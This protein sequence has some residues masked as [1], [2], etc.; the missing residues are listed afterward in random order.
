MQQPQQQQQ[1]GDEGT[2]GA[3]TQS[4]Q[5]GSMQQSSHNHQHL[6]QDQHMTEALELPD[7][8]SSTPNSTHFSSSLTSPSQG[9]L[10]VAE[11]S[12]A[13]QAREA[14]LDSSIHPASSAGTT[15]PNDAAI[16]AQASH[17]RSDAAGEAMY[18]DPASHSGMDAQPS[19]GMHAEAGPT[20]EAD[21]ADADADD[22]VADGMPDALESLAVASTEGHAPQMAVLA[23]LDQVCSLCTACSLAPTHAQHAFQPRSMHIMLISPVSST[24]C[25]SAPLQAQHADEPNS[26][27]AC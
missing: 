17:D 11:Q 15:P 24:A 16:V 22:M 25:S 3:F 26:S 14:L 18:A 10:P 7:G 23:S 8:N 19:Q 2:A 4:Q 5:T 21:T 20:E 1:A 27:A 13:A 6:L 12:G 9:A